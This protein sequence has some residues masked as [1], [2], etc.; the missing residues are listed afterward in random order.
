MS[1]ELYI[2]AHEAAIE[3]YLEE[4]PEATEAEAYEATADSA[5][6]RMTD[7]LAAQAD[8]YR[9]LKKDGML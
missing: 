6:T 4:H 2:D 8:H 5:Y 9:Q 3:D 1:K 7:N